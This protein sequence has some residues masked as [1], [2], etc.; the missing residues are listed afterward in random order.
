[1]DEKNERSRNKTY[2]C[3]STPVVPGEVI[4]HVPIKDFLGSSKGYV[5]CEKCGKSFL[6]SKQWIDKSLT[7]IIDDYFPMDEHVSQCKEEPR[8]G[9][10]TH[11]LKTERERERERESIS[12]FLLLVVE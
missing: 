11:Y 2:Y 12:Y 4:N 3:S 6:C 10:Y 1:M 7:Y 9:S 5:E 8:K